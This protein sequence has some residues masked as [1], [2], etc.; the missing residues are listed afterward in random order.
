MEN[1]SEDDNEDDEE[2][3]NDAED[4]EEMS[5]DN[6]DHS[7]EEDEEQEESESGDDFD[8]ALMSDV[9]KQLSKEEKKALR[10]KAKHDKLKAKKHSQKTESQ[11]KE[12]GVTRGVDFKSVQI[13]INFD[14]P[15]TAKNYVHRIGRTARYSIAPYEHY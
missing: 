2:D 4:N 10:N 1:G 6:A 3:E 15:R 5:E 14:F 13:V 11:D 12:Y 8:M 9:K 7:G